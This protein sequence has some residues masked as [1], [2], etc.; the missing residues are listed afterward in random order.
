MTKDR[1]CPSQ[2]TKTLSKPFFAI[3]EI[4]MCLKIITHAISQRRMHSSQMMILN[5]V[6]M[7][8]DLAKHHMT[9]FASNSPKCD[10]TCK[11]PNFEPILDF[12]FFPNAF[13]NEAL[14]QVKVKLLVDLGP[15]KFHLKGSPI[16][17]P[18][19]LNTI[20]NVCFIDSLV[21]RRQKM[22]C[23]EIV[24]KEILAVQTL[25][26]TAWCQLDKMKATLF[27]KMLRVL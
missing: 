20:P 4:F 17:C 19:C 8:L 2:Q 23:V 9:R 25:V 15:T 1:S 22:H 27:V 6:S 14:L 18:L 21:R 5:L 7:P 12:I 13:A 16:P 3:E 24:A 11:V 26:V 10:T